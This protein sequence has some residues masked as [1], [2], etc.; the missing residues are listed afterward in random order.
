MAHCLVQAGARGARGIP[1]VGIDTYPDGLV[2]GW[3]I[4]PHPYRPDE[5]EAEVDWGLMTVT[6]AHKHYA[7]MILG[8]YEGIRRSEARAA[9]HCADWALR[10]S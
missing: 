4:F 5:F 3:A 8:L 9:D 7:A 6:I 1:L 10:G 2:Q